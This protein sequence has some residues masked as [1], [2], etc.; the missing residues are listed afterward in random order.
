MQE[1]NQKNW[2]VLSIVADQTPFVVIE[3]AFRNKAMEP[4]LDTSCVGMRLLY[5]TIFGVLF[6][7]SI[8]FSIH[9]ATPTVPALELIPAVRVRG[10]LAITHCLCLFCSRQLE[11]LFKFI[12][13]RYTER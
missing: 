3:K 8:H 1:K 7:L 12:V 13:N 4:G 6:I 2:N 5:M 10:L 11:Y 9:S